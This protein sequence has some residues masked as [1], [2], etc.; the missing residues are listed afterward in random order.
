M[1]ILNKKR[2][3]FK[4]VSVA[5]FLLCWVIQIL[6]KIKSKSMLA[7]LAL[8]MAADFLTLQ[9]YLMPCCSAQLTDCTELV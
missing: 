2:Q 1:K 6:A 5:G 4:L 3:L 8:K 9:V 7:G